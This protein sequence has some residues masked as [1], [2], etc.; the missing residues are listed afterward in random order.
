[1]ND[2]KAIAAYIDA[3]AQTVGLPLDPAYREGVVRQFTG[4]ANIARLVMEF[5]LPPDI[6]PATVL[7]H[8]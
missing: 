2:T 4:V 7:R 6:E 5:P 8:D 3:A 1:M